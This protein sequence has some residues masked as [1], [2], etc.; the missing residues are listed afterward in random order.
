VKS[1]KSKFKSEKKDIIPLSLG[2]GGLHKA[3]GVR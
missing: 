3:G 1:E 2:R